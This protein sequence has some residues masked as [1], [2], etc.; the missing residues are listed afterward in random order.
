MAVRG[1]MRDDGYD[2]GLA[3]DEDADRPAGFACKEAFP[4]TPASACRM[5]RDE[6]AQR[7]L[8]NVRHHDAH[9]DR[10]VSQ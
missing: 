6:S 3:M 8:G 2:V 9:G 5:G 10:F 7:F 1:R 4:A